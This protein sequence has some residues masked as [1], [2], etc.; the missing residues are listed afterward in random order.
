M[1]RLSRQ[2]EGNG[3]R[4]ETWVDYVTA[5]SRIPEPCIAHEPIRSMGVTEQGTESRDTRCMI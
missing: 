5:A 2:D 4:W 3:S 1:V